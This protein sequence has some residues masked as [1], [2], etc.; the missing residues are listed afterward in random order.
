[1]PYIYVTCQIQVPFGT[2]MKILSCRPFSSTRISTHKRPAHTRM[3][4]AKCRT[5]VTHVWKNKKFS[6][7]DLAPLNVHLFTQET[8]TKYIYVL[9]TYVGMIDVSVDFKTSNFG[10]DT[11]WYQSGRGS[12]VY[13]LPCYTPTYNNVTQPHTTT[14]NRFL[15][16]E[17]FFKHNLVW[18]R[19]MLSSIHF[20][21]LNSHIQQ[22]TATHC[23]T[24]NTLP[25]TVL[26][27]ETHLMWAKLQHSATHCNTHRDKP[28]ARQNVCVPQRIGNPTPNIYLRECVY[29]RV[30]MRV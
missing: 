1:M 4:C 20:T 30:C 11:T 23:D 21:L 29:S 26:H 2:C 9:F 3:W 24:R 15:K 17:S 18:K 12:Q 10:S 16:F 6:L 13:T 7:L 25:H 14:H 22:H 19:Q 28:L 5:H 8:C 27:T